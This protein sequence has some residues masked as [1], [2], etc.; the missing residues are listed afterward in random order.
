MRRYSGIRWSRIAWRHWGI[1]PEKH[2]KKSDGKKI[3]K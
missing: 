1:E 2:K 3:Q